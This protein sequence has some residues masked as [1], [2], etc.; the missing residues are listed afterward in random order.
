M[1]GPRPGV[2][3]TSRAVGARLGCSSRSTG[4]KYRGGTTGG[5]VI[6]IGPVSGTMAPARNA[7]QVACSKAASVLALRCIHQERH[8]AQQQERHCPSSP[9]QIAI[10]APFTTEKRSVL[11]PN[12]RTCA[13]SLRSRSSPVRFEPA[14]APAPACS[15]SD[16][17]SATQHPPT[18]PASN[19]HLHRIPSP[20]PSSTHPPALYLSLSLPALRA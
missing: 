19:E 13:H 12:Y 9:F 6:R 7:C 3:L 11:V 8:R 2:R 4:R 16:R 5:W 20:A 14:P 10:A 15:Q 1:G 17:V 18:A